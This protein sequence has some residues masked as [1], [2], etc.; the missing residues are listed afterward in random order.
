MG[1]LNHIVNVDRGT[2][3]SA[4]SLLRRVTLLAALGLVISA[5]THAQSATNFDTKVLTPKAKTPKKDKAATPSSKEAGPVSATPSRFVGEADLDAYVES[6]SAVLSM[7]DRA[8]DPFGQLQDPDAKPVIKP[9]IAKKTTRVQSIQAT[10]FSDIIRL[11]KVTTVMP[12][13]KRF[14]VETRSFKQGGRIPLGFRGKTINVEI[15]S[16]SSRQIDLRNL[17]TGETASIK[18]DL[19]PVGMTPGTRGITAPGMVPD[20]PNAPINLD[21][22]TGVPTDETSQNR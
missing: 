17:E 6:F 7:K 19:L 22:D 4:V 10:P 3:A 16:V 20:S 15:T 9:S 8:T 2:R 14:L 11:I 5:S 12:G 21:N 18:M 13:E 1:T